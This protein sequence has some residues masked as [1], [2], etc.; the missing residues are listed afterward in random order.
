[1]AVASLIDIFNHALGYLGSRRDIVSES[2]GTKEQ[3]LCSLYYP[4]VRDV[5]LEMHDWNFARREATL[6]DQD[7]PPSNWG[8]K[9][10]YPT[11][12]IKARRLVRVSA[13]RNDLHV[14]FE[15]ASDG[16]LRVIYTDMANACLI[17]TEK[18]TATA[19]WDSAFDDALAL[20][21]A[22]KLAVPLSAGAGVTVESLRFQAGSA[23]ERALVA[24]GIEGA[25][26]PEPLSQSMQARG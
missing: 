9:Y 15:V 25:R 1:M 23:V 21:L 22:V 11:D 6:T 13:P 20:G 2:D 24:D 10:T 16:S 3:Q 7:D 19:R 4:L 12:C 17:Y 14:P 8:F 26:D 18:V 5:M